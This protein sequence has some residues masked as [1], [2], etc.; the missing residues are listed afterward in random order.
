MCIIELWGGV[1]ISILLRMEYNA[2]SRWDNP[3]PE[4]CLT[5]PRTVISW[6]SPSHTAIRERPVAVLYNPLSIIGA[7]NQRTEN[8]LFGHR[9][10]GRCTCGI[11]K[12]IDPNFIDPRA[13][14]MASSPEGETSISVGFFLHREDVLLYLLIDQNRPTPN[15]LHHIDERWHN[16]PLIQKNLFGTR[17]I[18]RSSEMAIR[19]ESVLQKKSPTP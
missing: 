14:T 11:H 15:H 12:I 10:H 7:K 4:I 1:N 8:L 16:D 3:T 18:I 5:R 19:S 17:W 13:T 9:Y 6:E 2:V